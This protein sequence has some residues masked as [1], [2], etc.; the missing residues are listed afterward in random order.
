MS[1]KN[2]L[3]KVLRRF[4][5]ELHGTGYLQSLAK[6][7]FKKNEFNF[8]REFYG[9]QQIVIFDVGANRGHTIS[10]FFELFPTAK[11]FAYEPISLLCNELQIRFKNNQQLIL[12]C[13]GIGQVTGEMNFYINKSLDTSSF[14][15]SKKTGLNSDAQV[16]TIDEVMVPVK[17]IDYCFKEQNLSAIHILKLDIQGGE[18]KALHGAS[19]LLAEKKIGLIYTEAYFVQQYVDQP[20]F[21]DIALFLQSFGYVL[22]DIYNPIYGKNKLAWCDAVFILKELK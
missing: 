1:I 8:F 9:E 11:I 10:R 6:G 22:Q 17:T 5:V 7:E 2:K 4:N 15:P 14:L 21:Y 13:C 19:H 16:Q 18:L 12:E 20:L 3:N